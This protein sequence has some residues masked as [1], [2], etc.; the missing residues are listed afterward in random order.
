MKKMSKLKEVEHDRN[1][2]KVTAG[3]IMLLLLL[4]SIST[5]YI[6]FDRVKLQEENQELREG[7]EDFLKYNVNTQKYAAERLN[8]THEEFLDDYLRYQMEC[9]ITEDCEVIE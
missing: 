3:I 5:A 4:M 7:L 6:E 2:L 9:L 1:N 8:I